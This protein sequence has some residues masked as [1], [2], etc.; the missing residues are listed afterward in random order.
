MKNTKP[1]KRSASAK[2]ANKKPQKKS[3]QGATREYQSDAHAGV[4]WMRYLLLLAFV[5]GLTWGAGNVPWHKVYNKAYQ[6]ANRPLA[7]ISI[8]S[9]FRYVSKQA[10]KEIIS[11]KLDGSF[12][13]LD[14]QDVKSA[15]ERD[16]WV[17]SVTIER[18]W[19][20]SLKLNVVEHTP[21]A[22]WN[23]NGYINRE[24]VLIMVDSNSAL[25]DLPRLSG[26]ESESTSLAKNYSLFSEFLKRNQLRIT[27][28]SL[29]ST[30]SWQLHLDQGFVLVLG[31]E[32]IEKKL[33]D[34]LYVYENVLKNEKNKIARIDMRYEKGL[35]V[36]WKDDPALVAANASQ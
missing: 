24:G 8:E 12:V 14:L 6:A 16:P 21:I 17:E 30:L 4:K 29:T 22:R 18:I 19:P 33:K 36:D 9:E 31:R 35:A 23:D 7:N 25:A 28:L 27:E 15:I 1:Y 34:F 10:L 20:D 11:S 26:L 32:N 3:A 2:T 5:S 13:D